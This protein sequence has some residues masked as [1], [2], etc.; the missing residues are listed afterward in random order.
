M[1]GEYLNKKRVTVKFF[2]LA[3]VVAFS[4]FVVAEARIVIAAET[5]LSETIVGGLFTGVAT[6]LPESS[7]PLRQSGREP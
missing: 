7:L 6:T 5:K 3:A 2:I 4:G 1:E